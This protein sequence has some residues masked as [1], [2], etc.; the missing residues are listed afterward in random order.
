VALTPEQAAEKFDAQKASIQGTSYVLAD[1]RVTILSGP[2]L[3]PT[4]DPSKYGISIRVRV[5]DNVTL[6]VLKDNYIFNVYN[7]PLPNDNPTNAEIV[8]AFKDIIY[9]HLRQVVGR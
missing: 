7:P 8:Q 6:I 2:I 1:L 3:R 9:P 4:T 5:Q